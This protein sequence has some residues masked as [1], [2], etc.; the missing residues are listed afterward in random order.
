[1]IEFLLQTGLAGLIATQSVI[2]AAEPFEPERIEACR[3]VD[4]QI[5]GRNPHPSE[6]RCRFDVRGPG[7]FG[8]LSH[9]DV[10]VYQPATPMPGTHMIGVPGQPRPF[11]FETFEQWEWRV[12]RR[13]YGPDIHRTYRDLDVL[14]P[15]FAAL[16]RVFEDRLAG[17]GVRA[18]R[19]ETWRSPERQG[20]L[21]QQGRSRPGP[22]V[23]T[24]LTSWHSQMD[25]SGR[26][27]GRAVDYD[28]EP[29]AMRRFHQIAEEVGLVTYG[30]DSHD[31]GHVYL[32][33]TDDALEREIIY[34]RT[35][36]RVPEVTLATGLPV[37]RSLPPGGVSFLRSRSLSFAELPFIPFPVPA[38]ATWSPLGMMVL[39]LD[40]GSR[41]SSGTS[42]TPGS[43]SRPIGPGPASLHS[44]PR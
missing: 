26:P 13:S 16:V 22:L 35:I 3:E 17:S 31:P 18:A 39:S 20:Y 5:L 33:L 6:L 15:A 28:V 25:T 14:D 7:R 10:P 29:G 12:L 24:T 44:E 38:L 19:L 42:E 1:M 32:P 8:L 23:T 37:D 43:H 11:A 9:T 2:P 41:V 21:F 36:P 40:P 34:L 30:H 27:A 4:Y